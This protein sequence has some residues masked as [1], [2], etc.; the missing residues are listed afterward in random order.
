MPEEEWITV[1]N[2]HESIVD[3]ELFEKSTGYEKS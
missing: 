1:K 3:K 2:M